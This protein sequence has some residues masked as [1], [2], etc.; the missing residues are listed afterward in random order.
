MRTWF[1]SNQYTRSLA[2]RILLF[3]AFVFVFLPGCNKDSS[4]PIVADEEFDIITEPLR[5][6]LSNITITPYFNDSINIKFDY[7]RSDSFYCYDIYYVADGKDHYLDSAFTN[8][9][10]LHFSGSNDNLKYFYNAHFRVDYCLYYFDDYFKNYN[11][12]G[13]NLFRFYIDKK[14]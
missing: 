10:T 2:M 5:G 9:I 7:A 12:T 14:N 1:A 13:G 6:S 8:N 11:Y 3:L 4:S